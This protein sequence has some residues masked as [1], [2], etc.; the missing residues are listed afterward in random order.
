MIAA[1]FLFG[2]SQWRSTQLYEALSWP[3]T[4][5]LANGGFQSSTLSQG[6]NQS[7][8][9]ACSAQKPSGSS[10]ARFQSAWY[11]SRL[12]MWACRANSG[13]G[14]KTRVSFRTL[15]IDPP[16]GSAVMVAGSAVAWVVRGKLDNG[17]S[18]PAS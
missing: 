2:P 15:V 14:G 8:A 5:H 4:N 10:L 18:L 9:S 16:P 3:P 7:S 6:L 17:K 11:C 1:L 12:E 13:G